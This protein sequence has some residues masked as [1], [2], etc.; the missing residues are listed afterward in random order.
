MKK[1]FLTSLVAVFAA[2][3]AQASS[4]INDNPLYRPGSN[5]FY[6]MT[7]LMSHSENA[8]S[9][10]LTEQFGYGITDRMAVSVE[11]SM[12]EGDWFDS[13][14]WGPLT[15]GLDYRVLNDA[16]WKADVYGSYTVNPVWGYGLSFLDENV[17]MYDWVVGVRAGYMTKM[18]TI[19]GHVEFDYRNT[20]S[21]NWGDDGWH[22][23]R[24][25]VDGFLSLNDN[26]ALLIGAEYTGWLDDEFENAGTWDAKFGVN[27]NIDVNKFVAA[28]ITSDMSHETGD[29][30]VSDGFGFGAK[31]GIQ[32]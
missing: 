6:S 10:A 5:Q 9:W 30:E 25:G 4:A 29:W 19:A 7:S 28:Y 12:A 11:T 22:S 13:N 3:A 18:W 20:E 8:D 15:L 31:F 2:S 23:I 21:F 16:N 17:T 26:W 24:A 1:I 27:Y 14:S 32:F